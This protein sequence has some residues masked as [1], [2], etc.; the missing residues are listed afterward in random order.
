[1]GT[2]HTPA[3]RTLHPRFW[4]LFQMFG[5]THILHHLIEKENEDACVPHLSEYTHING[6]GDA[7]VPH[8]G[9]MNTML[10]G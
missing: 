4:E 2:P 8:A 10:I 9:G 1:M 3:G 5:M 6:D 7:C